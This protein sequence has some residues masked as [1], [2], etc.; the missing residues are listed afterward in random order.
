MAKTKTVGTI[1]TGE[2][3]KLKSY[4]MYMEASK[5]FGDAKTNA[6]KAKKILRD[7]LKKALKLEGNIDFSITSQ[8]A[9]V[10]ENLEPKAEG[11]QRGT[12]LSIS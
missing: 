6:Q 2:M 5:T 1:P 8:G 12:I 4:A 3:K 7:E 11:R 10:T 9:L